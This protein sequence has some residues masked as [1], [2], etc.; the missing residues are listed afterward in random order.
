[1]SGRN[2]QVMRTFYSPFSALHYIFLCNYC[3]RD[4]K[5]TKNPSCYRDHIVCISSPFF[6]M[7]RD[8]R[9]M[10]DCICKILCVGVKAVICQLFFL[11]ISLQRNSRCTF[12]QPVTFGRHRLAKGVKLAALI[13]PLED[14]K[15]S[16]QMLTE[17]K[18]F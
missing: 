12:Q 10:T 9:W 3:C 15:H 5:K 1:M 11:T 4:E 6:G 17:R 14:E 13:Q 7:V 2:Q 8:K 18:L 16:N